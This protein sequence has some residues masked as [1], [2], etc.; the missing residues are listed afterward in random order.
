MKSNILLTLLMFLPF[1][2]FGQEIKTSKI[3]L[4]KKENESFKKIETL[5]ETYDKQGRLIKEV[6]TDF[7]SKS[8]RQQIRTLKYQGEK[9]ILSETYFYDNEM[10]EPLL[11]YKNLT[12]IEKVS[13]NTT[14][15][16]A[17][18]ERINKSPFY[19]NSN[20]K[21]EQ[22]F[23]TDEAQSGELID[24]LEFEFS[25]A[26]NEDDANTITIIKTYSPPIKGISQAEFKYRKYRKEVGKLTLSSATFFEPQKDSTIKEFYV[27]FLEDP[28]LRYSV[29]GSKIT[30]KEGL[31]I[32]EYHHSY[33][34]EYNQNNHWIKQ[35][36]F[37]R[38]E[39][40]ERKIREI[41]Y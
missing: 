40:K 37:Y 22:A 21:E 28:P 13:P 9:E 10:S 23:F 18:F 27:S 15:K 20:I 7:K 24:S 17:N 35:T 8:K 12:Q 1:I 4:E 33:E 14:I 16:K 2:S 11:C 5:E 38:G 32:K 26:L 29:E 19:Y 30:N 31:T 34:Y 41:K 3:T 25:M 6:L 39:E 36:T